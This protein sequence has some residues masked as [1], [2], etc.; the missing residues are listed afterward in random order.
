MDGQFVP[1]NPI[2]FEGR[3]PRNPWHKRDMKEIITGL[4]LS[5]NLKLCLDAGDSASY[6]SGQSWL[7]LSGNGYDFFRGADGSATATDPTFNGSAGGLSASE[8]WS[9]DG[10]D[11]FTYDSANETWMQNLHKD[12]A[13]FTIAFWFYWVDP[14]TGSGIWGNT[15]ANSNNIGMDIGTSTGFPICQLLVR[16]GSAP[17]AVAVNSHPGALVEN[18]WNFVAFSVDEAAGADGSHGRTG[19][20]FTLRNG[21]M[22]SPSASNATYTTQIGAQGNAGILM[23]SGSR[24]AALMAWEGTSL[25]P[26]QTGAIFTATRGRFGV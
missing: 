9:F 20:N 11:Y 15:Q 24:L 13:L 3:G 17:V 8:Y 25:S 5:S 19:G 10:G 22:T 23:K 4:G 6:T 26:A 7:D 12:N 1:G 2:Q 14:T 16:K 18:A 21:T